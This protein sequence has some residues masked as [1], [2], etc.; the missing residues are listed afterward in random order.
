MAPSNQRAKGWIQKILLCEFPGEDFASGRL[1][2][3]RLL[4]RALSA[5]PRNAAGR[6]CGADHQSGHP[7]RSAPFRLWRGALGIQ[8]VYDGVLDFIAVAKNVA[9][10]ETQDM[11]KILDAG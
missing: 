1:L 7:F 10:I 11:R 6:G 3:A 8:A 4:S 5:F 2:W 9:F